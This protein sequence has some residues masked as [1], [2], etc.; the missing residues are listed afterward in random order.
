MPADLPGDVPQDTYR[1][2]PEEIAEFQ[3]RL[4][5]EPVA[6]S[7]IR[8]QVDDGRVLATMD[9]PRYLQRGVALDTDTSIALYRLVQLFGTPN[10]PGLEAGA[11]QPP[12]ELTTWQYLFRVTDAPES[13]PERTFLVSVYDYK[14][15][16]SVG[17]SEWYSPE[18]GDDPG[19]VALG[20]SPDPLPSATGENGERIPDEPILE[21][22]VQLV[23]SMVEH[24]VEA[25]YKGLHV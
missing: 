4:T 5:V 18:P 7:A 12:R 24:A 10:L 16:V 20:P 8:E 11:D 3:E 9:I 23:L 22:F 6:P 21:T 25:T 1:Y 15:D 14:T 17:L 2:D 13:G 19:R